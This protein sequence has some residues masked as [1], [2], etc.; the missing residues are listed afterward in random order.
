MKFSVLIKLTILA[1]VVAANLFS[2]SPAKASTFD[3]QEMAVDSIVAIAAPYRHGY[4][5]VVIE[6]VAR[7]S[8]MLVRTGYCS[9]SG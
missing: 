5:L 9:C 3:E 6:Q 1:N 4:N 2:L 7:T 8:S